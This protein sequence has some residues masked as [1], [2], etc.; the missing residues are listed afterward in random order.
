METNCKGAGE[1][2]VLAYFHSKTGPSLSGAGWRRDRQNGTTNKM[3]TVEE[4]RKLATY[5]F[6]FE[7]Q[8]LV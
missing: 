8:Q 7:R 6:S 5:C 1:S 4:S 3:P 2:S